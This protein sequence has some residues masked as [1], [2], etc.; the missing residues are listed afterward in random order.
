MAAKTASLIAKLSDKRHQTEA[1]FA[2]AAAPHADYVPAL[3]DY[4][5]SL[6]DDKR[7]MMAEL[8]DDFG[9]G[10]D[11]EQVLRVLAKVGDER[12]V[13]LL[14]TLLVQARKIVWWNLLLE[15]AQR[16]DSPALIPALVGWRDGKAAVNPS[17]DGVARADRVISALRR[18]AKK[19]KLPIPDAPSVAPL[20]T[21]PK[22]KP[23][24]RKKR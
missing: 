24:T 7:L 1:L 3:V 12:A 20:A 21:A 14:E 11:N 23:A 2:M 10:W 16:I 13:T 8:G 19:R 18:S 4:H 17:W 5:Q 15:A 6:L 9:Q 22:K